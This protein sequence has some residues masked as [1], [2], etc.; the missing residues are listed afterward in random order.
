MAAAKAVKAQKGVNTYFMRA[1]VWALGW[2]VGERRSP[3]IRYNS[4]LRITRTLPYEEAL[5]LLLFYLTKVR[6][7]PSSPSLHEL[8]QDTRGGDWGGGEG[9]GRGEGG[10][11]RAVLAGR[12]RFVWLVGRAIRRTRPRRKERI[13]VRA[14]QLSGP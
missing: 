10:G 8:S 11:A 14:A 5:F 12:G 7:M 6:W 13:F 1:V 9:R 4:P 3:Q 2:W